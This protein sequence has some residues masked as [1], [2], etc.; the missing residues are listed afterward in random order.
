M[1]LVTG[2]RMIPPPSI[3][4]SRMP[5]LSTKKSGYRQVT[6]WLHTTSPAPFQATWV[7]TTSRFKV[8]VCGT[9]TWLEIL[10][11]I[12]ISTGGVTGSGGGAN[13][14][15]PVL[16]FQGKQNNRNDPERNK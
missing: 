3:I 9:P 15:L 1:P 10:T 13:F 11:Y 6:T 2:S 14:T 7:Y 4:A 16:L 8:R 5:L 12:P